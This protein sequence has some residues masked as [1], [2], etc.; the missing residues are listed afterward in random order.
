MS[1]RDGGEGGSRG[2]EE[3]GE[4]GGAEEGSGMGERREGI[5][6]M[7]EKGEERVGLKGKEREGVTFQRGGRERGERRNLIYFKLRAVR[8]GG[9][10]GEGSD[11]KE[12][13]T[14]GHTGVI[15]AVKINLNPRNSIRRRHNPWLAD[16]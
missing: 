7:E 14:E 4:G 8:R 10:R 2:G 13:A 3:G 6:G 9:G 15:P 1:K 11:G 12:G 5:E 16:S